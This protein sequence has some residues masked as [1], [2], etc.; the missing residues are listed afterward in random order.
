MEVGINTTTSGACR[1]WQRRV[2][3]NGCASDRQQA[4]IVFDVVVEMVEQ[5]PA[6]K[7]LVELS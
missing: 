4:S 3:A 1:D 2:L 6:L 5:C 7:R